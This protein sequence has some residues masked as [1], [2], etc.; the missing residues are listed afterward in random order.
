MTAVEL[1]K[2]LE[3]QVG[4]LRWVVFRAPVAG[5][6]TTAVWW[7]ALAVADEF[8]TGTLVCA[9]VAEDEVVSCAEVT[10]DL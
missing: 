4:P 5:P 2:M 9:A 8:V 3:P 1:R 6:A 10:V 7:E